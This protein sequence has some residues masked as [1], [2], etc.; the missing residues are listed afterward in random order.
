MKKR[1]L[2]D[3]LCVYCATQLA[4]SEDHVFARQ[5]FVEN[6][7]VNLPKVPACLAC[8]NEKSKLELY[9]ATVLPFGGLNPDA[10][11]ILEQDVP[12]RL[13]GNLK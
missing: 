11:T 10:R 8:N 5:F 1:R 13:L 12:R 3:K 4:E 6:R 9:L 7:R 2:R